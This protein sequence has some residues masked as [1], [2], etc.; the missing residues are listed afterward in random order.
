MLWASRTKLTLDLPDPATAV[1]LAMENGKFPVAILDNGD[2]V[3][4]GS[5]GDSTFIL[6]ELLRQKAQGWVMTI[7]DRQAAE[8]AFRAGV[9]QPFD[10]QVGGKTDKMH[11]EPVRVRGRIKSLHDGKFVEPETRHGGYRYWDMGLTAVI[12]EESSTPDLP[13][14][15]L[16]T[17]KRTMPNSLHSLISNGVYPQREKILVAK[18]TIAPLAAYEPIAARIIQVD[19]PGVTAVNPAR[20]TYK[21]VRRPL[22]GLQ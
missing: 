9:G 13:S 4:G 2:N 21:N 7:A 3:G 20:F 11:G 6:K 5:P 12:E 8:A 19:V 15:L 18:G 17:M 1:K 10:M 14:L 16:L 22:W